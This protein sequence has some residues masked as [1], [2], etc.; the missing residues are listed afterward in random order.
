LSKRQCG[1]FYDPRYGRSS[2][3]SGIYFR[4]LLTGYFTGIDSERGIAWRF[5][6]PLALRKLADRAPSSRPC[7]K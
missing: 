4:S 2:P 1:K 5:A 6:D 3:A 7:P